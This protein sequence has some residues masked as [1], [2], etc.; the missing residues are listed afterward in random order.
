MSTLDKELIS[1]VESTDSMNEE[2]KKPKKIYILPLMKP[3]C[4]ENEAHYQFIESMAETNPLLLEKI[5][6]W[7]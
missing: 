6:S 1:K 7:D 3:R 2:H 5:L 4:P